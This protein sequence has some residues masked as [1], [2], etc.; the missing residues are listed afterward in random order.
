MDK[1]RPQTPSQS[2]RRTG[3]W[4]WIGLL[5]ALA[6]NA[7]LRGHAFGPA[8]R[9]MTGLNAYPVTSA[10]SEPLDCDEA[11][12]GY[13]GK[14]LNDGAVMYR[15]LTE[16]KPPLGYWLFAG[17]VAI[18]GPTELTIRL[19]P[20]PFVLATTAIVWWV[21]RRLQGDLAALIAS[22]TFALVSTDPF[23]YGESANMEHMINLCSFSALA[24]LLAARSR[25]GGAASFASGVMLGLATLIKQTSALNVPLLAAAIVL[26]RE[27]GR[28]RGR[29]LLAFCAGTAT[30]LVLTVVALLA[31]G[32]AGSAWADVAHYGRALATE[33]PPAPNAPPWPLRW[34]TGNADPQGGLPWPFGDSTYLVW[35]GTGTWPVWLLAIPALAWFTRSRMATTERRW[36]A[37]WTLSAWVQVALPGLFWQHYYL[38]PVPGLAVLVGVFLADQ[39]TLTWTSPRR[40]AVHAC[41]LIFLASGLVWTARLQAVEYLG[42]SPEG[43]VKDRG[44]PQWLVNRALGRE[45]ARRT[46]GWRNPTLFVWGWQGPLYFYSGLKGV[47]PQVFVDDFLK[48][49]AGTDHPLARPRIERTMRDLRENPPTLIFAGY[50]PFPELRRF[51]EERYFPSQ[52]APGLWVERSVYGA[53]EGAAGR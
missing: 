21:A 35:W 18:G 26:D 13:I 24:F 34:V 46:A 2:T 27:E 12:Y 23:L 3:P 47:T 44:G 16:N 53:F 5:V 6:F 1:A 39:V 51:L 48:A 40:N 45:I 31:Q 32:A 7:W 10:E 36:V 28:P 17:A 43:L 37:V 25:P 30:A 14:R 4:P 8:L 33:T 20:L 38:L 42:V 9:D 15:D 22:L 29:R 52:I 50:P 11:I 19:M 41:M 49:H